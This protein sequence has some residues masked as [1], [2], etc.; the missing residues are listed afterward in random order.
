MSQSKELV[1]V[2]GAGASCEFN[3]PSGIELINAISENINKYQTPD[4]K[5]KCAEDFDELNRHYNGIDKSLEHI[6]KSMPLAKSIDNF[7]DCHRGNEMI[8]IGSKVAI[9]R[10]ILDAEKQS[11]LYHSK[12]IEDL[13]DFQSVKEKYK[14]SDKHKTSDPWIIKLFKLI[15][16]NCTKL[17][18]PDKLDKIAI[19]TFNYD[20]CIEHF[21]WYAFKVY[22]Q[23]SPQEAT[24][25]V[26][27]VKIFHP[28][29][30]VGT[31]PWMDDQ[32]HRAGFGA[33]PPANFLL[34][35][36][37]Q[38]KTFTE[39][40]KSETQEVVNIQNTIA[41]A[42]K[43]IFLGFSYQNMNLQ[44]LYHQDTSKPATENIYGTA[45]GLSK[46]DCEDIENKLQAFY[47]RH[48]S[49]IKQKIIIRNDL[50]CSELFDEYSRSINI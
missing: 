1:F 8:E 29:G 9:S 43:L 14:N 2:V 13:L 28:Y 40:T 18:L 21:L 47:A 35:I 34:T 12:N 26:I 45:F 31:L 36:A 10:C 20:R 19:I 49:Q 37:K 27:Q 24:D 16:E 4:D 6:R 22:Y 30:K 25:L 7:I 11:I 41:K 38:I 50:T 33:E 23:A 5:S 17:E 39:E 48:D 44:I 46:S 32:E 3:L 42:K 15:T